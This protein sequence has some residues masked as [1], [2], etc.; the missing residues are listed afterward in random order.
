MAWYED[1]WEAVSG[2][3]E[4]VWDWGGETLGLKD[5]SVD[6]TKNMGPDGPYAETYQGFDPNKFDPTKQPGYPQVNDALTR[7]GTAGS[8]MTG[9]AVSNLNVPTQAPNTS[10]TGVVNA[11]TPVTAGTTSTIPA[12]YEGSQV[13]SAQSRQ[14]QID[15][16]GMFG[17]SAAGLGPSVAPGMMRENAAIAAN[18]FGQAGSMANQG[19]RGA[20]IDA[21]LGYGN[22]LSQQQYQAQRA[23][24]DAA[25]A[26]LDANRDAI[27][28]QAALA[29]SGRGGGMTASLL[30]AQNN[31]ALQTAQA[32]T[33]AARQYGDA[34]QDANFQAATGVRQASAQQQQQ[35]MTLQAT[36]ERAGMEAARAREAGDARAAQAA[37]QEQ[38]HAMDMIADLSNS[39]RAGDM[40]ESGLAAQVDA[41]VQSGDIANADRALKASGMNAEM[42]FQ[43]GVISA[44]NALKIAQMNG[45]WQAAN[46]VLMNDT[47][48]FLAGLG[49]QLDM[50]SMQGFMQMVQMGL[51]SGM[52]LEMA[53]FEAFDNAKKNGINF[54]TGAGTVAT[55]NR[56]INKDMV[57]G[58]AKTFLPS[59]GGASSGGASGGAAAAGGASGGAG[60]AIAGTIASDVTA[61]DII[62]P[63]T[64]PD[65]RAALPHQYTYKP[66][67][68]LNEEGDDEYDTDEVFDGPMAQ[69][70]PLD[71]RVKDARNEDRERVDQGRLLLSMATALG[72]AQRRLDVLDGGGPDMGAEDQTPD[73]NEDVM[74]S[75]LEAGA[76]SESTD[77][78]MRPEEDDNTMQYLMGGMH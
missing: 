26:T 30:N 7:M 63:G 66:G 72:E 29:A 5:D 38:Q 2:T 12:N 58:V 45:D 15:A 20:A 77:M 64:I 48:K 44:E 57:A 14:V 54:D 11:P 74:A 42:A 55:G 23:A 16:L 37:A 47:Q 6:L 10:L 61:K 9:A 60:S 32:N 46:N 65:F 59:A 22:A 17:A 35:M 33:T 68:F 53:K 28:G 43:A 18:A 70:L 19:Y 27:R 62:G 75:L 8:A 78:P 40:E 3:A 34:I 1:A 76:P 56:E 36:A 73:P 71:T 21:N 49:V 13:N 69:D 67:A 31:A 39:I 51:E 50:A 25:R 41:M 24:Q 52:S 4:D